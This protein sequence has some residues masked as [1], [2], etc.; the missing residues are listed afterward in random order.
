METTERGHS[1]REKTRRPQGI[2]LVETLI[3]VAILCALAGV[4]WMM[5]GPS[6][7]ARAVESAIRN[8]LRQLSAAT[9]IYVGDHDGELPLSITSFKKV[10]LQAPLKPTVV[11]RFQP[12]CG[13]GKAQYFLMR[14]ESIVEMEKKYRADYPF[15]NAVNPFFKAPFVCRKP[16]VQEAFMTFGDGRWQETRREKV[17][18][19]GARLDGSVDWFPSWEQW[20]EEFAAKAH[21]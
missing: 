9:Q 12:E 10:G 7:R 1:I 8:D 20:E 4:A 14:N 21:G 5:L 3:V 2:T 11:T 18:V 13:T 15:S 17:M 6:A 19:L 16:G